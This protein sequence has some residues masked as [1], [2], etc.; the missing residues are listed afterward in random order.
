MG[1]GDETSVGRDPIKWRLI[2]SREQKR[3][4]RSVA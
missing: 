2:N 1:K 3:V 4:H